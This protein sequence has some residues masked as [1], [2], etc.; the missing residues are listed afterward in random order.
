[1]AAVHDP[2][3]VLWIGDSITASGYSDITTRLGNLG[4]P[5]C[6][7]GQPGRTAAQGV[8][9]MR[10]YFRAGLVAPTMVLALGTNDASDPAL[11]ADFGCQVNNAMFAAG[12]TRR[13]YWINVYN[14][15]SAA[16]LE[17]SRAINNALVTEDRAH[18]NLAKSEW[19]GYIIDRLSLLQADQVHP[20]GAGNSAR[21]VNLENDAWGWHPLWTQ[22][23]GQ[24][25]TYR[26]CAF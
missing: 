9:V 12:A 22:T 18:T 3:G 17:G 7:N 15:T 24:G 21:T 23:P 14:G 26:A 19:Y 20:T 13:V 2:D 11:V 25:T 16:T 8:E 6:V 4:H 1:L 10:Q 5:V